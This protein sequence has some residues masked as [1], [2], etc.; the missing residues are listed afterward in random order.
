MKEFIKINTGITLTEKMA[1]QLEEYCSFLTEENKKFNLTAITDREEIYEKH[2]ADSMLG[3]VFIK[4][5]QTLCDIGSGAGFPGI[6][7]KI[8]RPD[9]KVTLVD[10]LAKRVAFTEQAAAKLGLKLTCVHERA[11]DFA[12]NR[13]GVFDAVTARAVAPLAVLLEYT[14]APVKTGGIV[15]AYKTDGQETK[16]A[17]RAAEILGLKE[18]TFRDF[19]LPSGS[20]RRLIVYRKVRETPVKYPRGQNKPRKNPL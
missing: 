13:R 15:L 20:R 1:A 19:I 8:L 3:S 18:E 9:I 12:R 2:F 14:A 16:E 7:L 17:G 4:E 6:P 11:E 5:G 10:S